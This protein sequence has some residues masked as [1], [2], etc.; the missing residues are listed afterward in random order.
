MEN[1]DILKNK[2]EDVSAKDWVVRMYQTVLGI[3]HSNDG[4]CRHV[5]DA[6]KVLGLPLWKKNI[7]DPMPCA[8]K[9]I[10]MYRTIKK[11]TWFSTAIIED[12]DFMVCIKCGHRI[13]EFSEQTTEYTEIVS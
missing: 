4:V 10:P 6:R 9:Y 8:H 11:S 2:P 1:K 3:A 13:Y 7:T 5:N 12:L